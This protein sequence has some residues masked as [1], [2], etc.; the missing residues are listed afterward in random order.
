[1]QSGDGHHRSTHPVPRACYPVLDQTGLMWG[2][3]GG[4]Q[5]R[6]GPT[7]KGPAEVQTQPI[8]SRRDRSSPVGAK[9]CF[10]TPIY[11]F[12][13]FL[14]WHSCTAPTV[15]TPELGRHVQCLRGHSQIR[16]SLHLCFNIYSRCPGSPSATPSWSQGQTRSPDR[17]TV[18]FGVT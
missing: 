16:R 1:M 18:W 7:V 14:V 10:P 6:V 11:A 2:L 12:S 8:R 9:N 13:Q 15:W 5:K 3:P 17:A 4:T